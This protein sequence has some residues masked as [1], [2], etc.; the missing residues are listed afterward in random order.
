MKI[1]PYIIGRFVAR[2]AIG[3]AGAINRTYGVNYE[4]QVEAETA[5]PG[6]FVKSTAPYNILNRK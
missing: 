1:A 2:Q 5:F 6:Y 4:L 3:Q